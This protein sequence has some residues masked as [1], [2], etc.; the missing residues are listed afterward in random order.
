MRNTL[1]LPL[2]GAAVV[3]AGAFL[4]R[5]TRRPAL[6]TP[7]VVPLPVDRNGTGKESRPPLPDRLRAQ[8]F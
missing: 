3:T 2:V 6:A 8:G 7:K 4:V 5:L 1:V